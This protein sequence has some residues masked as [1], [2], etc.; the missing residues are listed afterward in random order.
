ML[1]IFRRKSLVGALAPEVAKALQVI[2]TSMMNQLILVRALEVG[3]SDDE[4]GGLIEAFC[5]DY[6]LDQV[7][8]VRKI[9]VLRYALKRYREEEIRG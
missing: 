3:A 2:R 5:E 1:K 9:D 6:G 8:P 4:S 7:D